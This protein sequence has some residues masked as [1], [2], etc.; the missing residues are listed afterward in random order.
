MCKP[1]CACYV[2]DCVNRWNVCA[3]ELI[4]L[5][6]AALHLDAGVLE[7]DIFDVAL[8]ADSIQRKIS[9][10]SFLC[11]V[12]LLDDDFN[13]LTLLLCGEHLGF[14]KDLHAITFK[15][16]TKLLRN[17]FVFHRKDTVQHFDNRHLG[18]E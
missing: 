15:R 11:S 7:S 4:N 5:D 14:G 9:R 18:T 17:V 10:Q 16:L 2:A 12:L 6:P 3:T 13:A 8:H 1:W